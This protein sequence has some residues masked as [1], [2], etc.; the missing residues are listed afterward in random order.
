MHKKLL[1]VLLV[2]AVWASLT[3]AASAQGLTIRQKTTSSGMPG[4]QGGRELT[5][6]IY[7]GPAAIRHTSG[8]E[9]DSI[10]QFEQKKFISLNHKKKTY[11]EMTFE[12]LQQMG[13]KAAQQMA[14]NKEAME[15]MRQMLGEK[16]GQ[17]SVADKGPGEPI[18]GHATH[19]YLIGMPPIQLELSTA[20]DLEVPAA[21][22]DAL[23]LKAPANPFLDM[24]KMFDAF[25]QVK[26]VSLKT[27]MTMSMMGMN[28]TTTT[29]ATSIDKAPV[30][31]STFDIPA[32]YKKVD[33]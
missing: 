29:V 18:L 2:M 27:V 5:E 4:G 19:Q 11:S 1:I 10:I 12:E 25:K 30:P 20:P 3:V 26:G 8:E 31:A 22:Y 16:A 24:G 17:I 13:D 23:K 15:A 7:F 14:E 21:Y 9:S 6:T 32:G 28:M 33:F